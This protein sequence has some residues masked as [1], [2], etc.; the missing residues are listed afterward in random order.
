LGGLFALVVLAWIA[1]LYLS[2]V[3]RA[4]LLAQH[5]LKVN[6]DNLEPGID[7]YLPA[8]IFKWP[9]FVR[10]KAHD[11]LPPGKDLRTT[12]E[13]ADLDRAS[14]YASTNFEILFPTRGRAATLR[15]S[16]DLVA[17]QVLS[18][19]ELL[20]MGFAF[21]GFGLDIIDDIYPLSDPAQEQYF[22]GTFPFCIG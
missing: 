6:E 22:T 16:F 8:T 15:Q 9:P 17:S 3:S 4:K 7:S 18:I 20:G 14:D 10:R 2:R 5:N 12:W 21:C 19:L 13:H 11:L 1:H